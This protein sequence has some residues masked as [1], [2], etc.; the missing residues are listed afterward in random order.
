MKYIISCCL[1]KRSEL[2]KKNPHDPWLAQV[3]LNHVKMLSMLIKFINR[4]KPALLETEKN[5]SQLGS[6]AMKLFQ[7]FF[8]IYLP[9]SL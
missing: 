1:F 8:F 4:W 9:V 7:K 2:H 6:L 3:N 5:Q